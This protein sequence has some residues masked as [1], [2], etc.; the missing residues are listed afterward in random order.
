M[1]CWSKI[2]GRLV[3]LILWC[4]WLLVCKSWF[5]TEEWSDGAGSSQAVLVVC[6]RRELEGRDAYVLLALRAW[7]PGGGCWFLAASS[8]H[9]GARRRRVVGY[10]VTTMGWRGHCL[11]GCEGI[12]PGEPFPRAE[13][14][15]AESKGIGS[16]SLLPRP[17][18]GFFFR[19]YLSCPGNS[20]MFK[21][22][23]FSLNTLHRSSLEVGDSQLSVTE[24]DL[25]LCSQWV[26]AAGWLCLACLLALTWELYGEKL[27]SECPYLKE[28][29]S[30][31]F[32]LLATGRG[33]TWVVGY[34]APFLCRQGENLY[35]WLVSIDFLEWAFSF[36]REIGTVLTF[37]D[38]TSLSIHY[39]EKHALCR[40]G[41]KSVL[42]KRPLIWIRNGSALQSV[43]TLR[44]IG[45]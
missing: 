11:I 2:Q 35:Q 36:K 9:T 28:V 5:K 42:R 7:A 8:G 39:L 31:M 29:T 41:K 27:R 15:L 30:Q 45:F 34:L 16:V 32:T 21:K 24:S 22:E 3:D 37:L 6:D 13:P 14:A 12:K 23:A 33:K 20:D 40:K 4:W 26:R 43:K 19:R 1:D 38:H 18:G 25:V 44:S 10:A 17:W